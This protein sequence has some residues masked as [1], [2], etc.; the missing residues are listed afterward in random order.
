MNE[1]NTD[2]KTLDCGMATAL[3]PDSDPASRHMVLNTYSL[4]RLQGRLV[5]V[6]NEQLTLN[7]IGTE[8]FEQLITVN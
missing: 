3:N 8:R 4:A 2:A 1:L 5:N 7:M 6:S